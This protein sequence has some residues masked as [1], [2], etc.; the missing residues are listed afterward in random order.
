MNKNIKMK[1]TY[2]LFEYLVKM[3]LENSEYDEVIIVNIFNKVQINKIDLLSTIDK[4]ILG[5]LLEKIKQTVEKSYL[6]LN[7]GTNRSIEKEF[8]NFYNQ[9]L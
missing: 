3:S 1:I 8:E 9:F 4:I 5:I 2:N 6:V 7:Y